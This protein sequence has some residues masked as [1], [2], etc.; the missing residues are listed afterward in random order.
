MPVTEWNGPQIL[1]DVERA[2][3]QAFE[4]VGKQLANQA[5]SDLSTPY[6]PASRPGQAPR[7]RTGKLAG[8]QAH[9]VTDEGGEIVL[10]V[11]SPGVAYAAIVASRRPWLA[12]SPTAALVTDAV[13]DNVRRT[14]G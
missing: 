1:T 9:K 2:T 13:A 14:L 6:P 10:R 5:R 3:R 11:G 12:V 8:A 4:D 7:K